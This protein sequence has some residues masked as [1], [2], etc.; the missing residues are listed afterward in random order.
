MNWRPSALGLTANAEGAQLV[1]AAK[2]SGN[3]AGLGLVGSCTER[4]R[5][6]GS[7]LEH[8]KK[9]GLSAGVCALLGLEMTGFVNDRGYK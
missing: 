2:G 4:S 5:S 1:D 9:K 7:R 6:T 3:F 8:Q